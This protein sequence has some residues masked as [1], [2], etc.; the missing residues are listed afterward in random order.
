MPLIAYEVSLEVVRSLRPVV[1]KLKTI[2]ANCHKQLVN[3]ASSVVHNL[4]EGQRRTGGDKRR[5]YEIAHGEAHEILAALD[6]AEAWG[7]ILPAAETRI[8]LDRLLALLWGLT[9]GQVR[10]CESGSTYLS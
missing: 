10:R 7:W 8:K 1:A 6:L 2:N 5:A 9:N 3:A 4:G